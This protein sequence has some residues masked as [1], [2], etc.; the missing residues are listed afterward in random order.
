MGNALSLLVLWEERDWERVRRRPGVTPKWED[1]LPAVG[2]NFECTVKDDRNQVS[3]F[4]LLQATVFKVKYY[5]QTVVAQ[6]IN[7]H[8]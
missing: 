7:K 2:T 8:I 3:V 6:V 5:H 1:L 4:Y